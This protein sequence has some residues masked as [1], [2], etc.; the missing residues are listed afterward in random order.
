MPS[1]SPD[2]GATGALTPLTIDPSLFPATY[3]AV[4]L[5]PQAVAQACQDLDGIAADAS[6]DPAGCKPEPRGVDTDSTSLVVGTDPEDRATISVEL[7]RVQSTLSEREALWEQCTDVT[8]TSN[9]VTTQVRTE[10][11]PPPPIGAD[12][13]LALRRTVTS[14][15]AAGEVTQSMLSLVAQ[16]DDIR[17]TATYMSFGELEPDSATLDGLFTAAVQKVTQGG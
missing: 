4:I 13:T 6:V 2:G 1:P 9:G 5:P 7:A 16:V 3:Q 14:G 15:G 8:A 11:V 17:I 12:E 10:I